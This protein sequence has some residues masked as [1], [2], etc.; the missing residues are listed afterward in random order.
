MYQSVGFWTRVGA[1]L[2]DGLIIYFPIALIT[3]ILFHSDIDGPIPSVIQ[4]LY[5]LIVPVFWYGYMVGKRILGIR[6]V[7]TDG[8]DVTI[9]TMLLRVF[10][11]GL[12]YGITLGIGYIVS[13]FMVGIRKDHRAIHDLIA[14]TYVT[15][16]P[17]EEAPPLEQVN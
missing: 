16:A 17:P 3:Y 1:F 7:K 11:G 4:S 12:V 2:L 10:V 13:A 15:D 8:T 14:G 6:I 5:M 9:G